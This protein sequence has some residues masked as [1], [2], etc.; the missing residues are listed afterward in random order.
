[1]FLFDIDLDT[2][3][4][5]PTDEVIEALRATGRVAATEQ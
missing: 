2:A 1:V 4:V 3:D 5:T